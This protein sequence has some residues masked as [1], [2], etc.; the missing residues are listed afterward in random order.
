M[1]LL[2]VTLLVLVE[3]VVGLLRRC[4]GVLCGAGVARSGSGLLADFR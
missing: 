3:V 2:A 4:S 1:M